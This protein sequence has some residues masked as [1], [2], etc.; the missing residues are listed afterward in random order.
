MLTSSRFFDPETNEVISWGEHYAI[1]PLIDEI[2]ELLPAAR[3]ESNKSH[4]DASRV[5]RS[6]ATEYPIS[7]S[8][9][10]FSRRAHVGAC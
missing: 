7:R 5:L 6:D 10:H 2:V 9:L 1:Q 3:A 8:D 4:W